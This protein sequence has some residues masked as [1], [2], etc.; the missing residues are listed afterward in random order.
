MKNIPKKT[1]RVF[2]ALISILLIASVTFMAGACKTTV[3]ENVT[4]TEISVTE[5]SNDSQKP[6]GETE[7][8]QAASTT[9][10]ATIKI[11]DGLGNEI[12]LE[13]P[14]EKVI[15]FTP[16]A[17]EIVDALNAMDKVAGVDLSL[18]HIFGD[19]TFIYVPVTKK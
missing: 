12:I 17:L 6:S 18:I 10:D 14:A 9:E 15:V 2:A 8:E 19:D 13:K 5:V 7:A 3:S 4:T 11:T 16:S 1:V